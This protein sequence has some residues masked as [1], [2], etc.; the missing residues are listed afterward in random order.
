VVKYRQK[1][2]TNKDIINDLKEKVIS[3]SDIFDTE[4]IEQETDVDHI[5]IL[6]KSK[7]TLEI[8]KYIKS[9]KGVSSRILRQKYKNFLKDKLWGKAFWSPSYYLATSGNVSLSKLI[10]YVEEQ[11]K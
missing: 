9:L 3:V 11:G 8:I 1:V 6:F 5:H 4:I 2:F 10:K 7:P